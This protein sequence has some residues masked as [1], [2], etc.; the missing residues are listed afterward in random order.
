MKFAMISLMTLVCCLGFAGLVYAQCPFSFSVDAGGWDSMM[1]TDADTDGK[2]E[3]TVTATSGAVA[4]GTITAIESDAK[5]ESLTII[6]DNGSDNKALVYVS[7]G[8]YSITLIESIDYDTNG[9]GV[10]VLE[11]L[12]MSGDI[13]SITVQKIG[14]L[15]TS[16]NVTGTITIDSRPDQSANILAFEI[17]GDLLDNVIVSDGRISS[18]I[19][20]GDIGTTGS[21]VSITVKEEIRNISCDNLYADIAVADGATPGP[22]R[23]IFVGGDGSGGSG[24]FD[25]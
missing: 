16:G 15:E 13:G 5:I 17:E 20:G 6:A 19:V 24:D 14:S 25:G 21:H 23:R 11:E 8:A 1:C 10:A 9:T 4:E 22:V 2:W 7:E 18:L 12:E 3:L